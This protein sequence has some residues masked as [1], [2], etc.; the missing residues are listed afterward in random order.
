MR[1]W[2]TESNVKAAQ[3]MAS[4]ITLGAF[5]ER[6]S[7]PTWCAYHDALEAQMGCWSLVDLELR[8]KI[9][10]KFCKSCD[11]YKPKEKP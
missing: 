11:C 9:S 1:Y 3:V 7:Q 2:H 5:M 10:P 6:Y 8:K 4:G